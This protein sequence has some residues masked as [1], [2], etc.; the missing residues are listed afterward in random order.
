M[1]ENSRKNSNIPLAC[2]C[3]KKLMQGGESA[4]LKEI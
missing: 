4:T 3:P 1:V 2:Y